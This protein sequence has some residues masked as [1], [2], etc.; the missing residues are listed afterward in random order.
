MFNFFDSASNHFF[1]DVTEKRVTTC[2]RFQN[3]IELHGK[4]WYNMFHSL[5]NKIT[6]FNMFNVMAYRTT[7]LVNLDMTDHCTTDFFI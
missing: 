2:F 6:C 1:N 4:T 3:P 7:G 5:E